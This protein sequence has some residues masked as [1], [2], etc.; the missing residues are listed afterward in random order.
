MKIYLSIKEREKKEA[1]QKAEKEAEQ[2]GLD[3]DLIQVKEDLPEKTH[4]RKLWKAKV[5]DF[6]LL[7][8][9]YKMPDVTKLNAVAKTLKDKAKVPGVEFYYENIII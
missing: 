1:M 7:P 4:S 2:L 9:E 6:K 5:V 8:E 3:K